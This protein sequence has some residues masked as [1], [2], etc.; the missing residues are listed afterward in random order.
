M[1][2]VIR[3][4]AI[5]DQCKRVIPGERQ[6]KGPQSRRGGRQDHAEALAELGLADELIT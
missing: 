3:F 5:K 1:G 4:A 2:A 6:P